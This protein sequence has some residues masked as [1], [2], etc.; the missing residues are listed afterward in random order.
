MSNLF[1]LPLQ[2]LEPGPWDMLTVE[3]MLWIP[4]YSAVTIFLLPPPNGID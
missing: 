4:Y 2:A 1:Q 3:V